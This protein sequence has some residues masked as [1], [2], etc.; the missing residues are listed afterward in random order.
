MQRS[1]CVRRLA[2]DD[3]EI[4]TKTKKHRPEQRRLVE[5]ETRRILKR[6]PNRHQE[7]FRNQPEL[8]VDPDPNVRMRVHRFLFKSLRGTNTTAN[9]SSIGRDRHVDNRTQ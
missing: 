9:F 3:A 2:P 7:D 4:S 8:A 1:M 5:G 6:F